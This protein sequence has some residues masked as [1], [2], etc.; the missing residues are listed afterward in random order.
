MSNWSLRISM[1][2]AIGFIA[3]GS[4][5]L[6]AA[7]QYNDDP[8]YAPPPRYDRRQDDPRRDP[9]WDRGPRDWGDRGGCSKRDVVDAARDEGFRRIDSVQSD[10]RRIVV[11]GWN[12][13]GPDRMTFANRRGCP[14]VH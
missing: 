1:I 14:V 13:G 2:A 7:A 10:G 8:D 5:P 6:G 12:D 3:A 4:M 11:R 9:N